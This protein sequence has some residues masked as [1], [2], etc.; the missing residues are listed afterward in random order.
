MSE[1]FIAEIKIVGFNFAPRGW[2]FCDGQ[3]LPINQNQSLFSLLGTSFGGNGRT[4]FA[5]PDLRG[6]TPTH[7]PG[8][9][10]G[11]KDGEEAHALTPAEMPSHRHSAKGS[12]ASATTGIASD[13]VLASTGG[14]R[15]PITPYGDNT[16]P[17]ALAADSVSP[18]GSGRGHDN[19]QPYLTLNFCIAL[20]GLF[21]SRN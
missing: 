3:L 1:P 11:A 18:T 20:S 9:N 15:R 19:M 17:V 4:D 12:S 21:P 6:R 10:P 8:P 2:A 7:A 5:L 14:G 13:N 16:T